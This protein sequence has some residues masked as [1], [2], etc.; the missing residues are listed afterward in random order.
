MKWWWPVAGR[1][2]GLDAIEWAKKGEALG[3]GEILLTCPWDADGTKKG[4]D[5]EMTRRRHQ[6]RPHPQSS[7]PAA[8]AP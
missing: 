8:A 7:P 3:A 1:P 2:T 5:L 4:F 6:R